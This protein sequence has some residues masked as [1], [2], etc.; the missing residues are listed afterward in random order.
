MFHRYSIGNFKCN[1]KCRKYTC[2]L[3]VRKNGRADAVESG[4]GKLAFGN[5]YLRTSL[6]SG[7]TQVDKVYTKIVTKDY[8]QVFKLSIADGK[9]KTEHCQ[10]DP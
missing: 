7:F 5:Y 6:C 1:G 4:N 3:S 8:L 2:I 10:E 9:Q